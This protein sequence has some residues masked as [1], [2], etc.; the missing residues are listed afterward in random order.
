MNMATMKKILDS[1]S[2][3]D[4]VAFLLIF[5]TLDNQACRIFVAELTVGLVSCAQ[6]IYNIP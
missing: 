4:K 5:C 3:R 6:S 1:N 2:I